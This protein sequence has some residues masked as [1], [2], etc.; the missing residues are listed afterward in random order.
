MQ[1][2]HIPIREQS[3]A[4]LIQF[5]TTLGHRPPATLAFRAS[6]RLSGRPV[7]A[8]LSS[9]VD[10]LRARTADP[11]TTRLALRLI[12]LRDDAEA[13]RDRAAN[14]AMLVGLF[15]FTSWFV[16]PVALA[17]VAGAL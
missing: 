9:T 6:P 8:N 3:D 15:V 10:R 12:A 7:H 14:R 2:S 16:V 4:A 5:F 17:A 13:K 11:L 1:Q